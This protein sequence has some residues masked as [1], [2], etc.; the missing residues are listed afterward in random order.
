[1][2]QLAA[3]YAK[4]KKMVGGNRER[5]HY[6]ESFGMPKE[7]FWK[8]TL[9]NPSIRRILAETEFSIRLSEERG[10]EFDA[11]LDEALDFMQARMDE[12]GVL[13]KRTCEEA[14][15]IL[16]P[17]SG[18]AKEYSLILAAHAHIDMNWMWSWNETVA[19]TI[20]T[21]QTMLKLMREYPD[22]HFSQSQ[23]AVYK[24]IEEYAPELKPEMMKYIKEGRWEVTASAWVETDKNMPSTESLLQ[25]IYQTK[26][27]LKEN[28]EIDP[29]SLNIDFSP[30]TFGHSANLPELDALGG[31][32]YYYHCRGLDGDNALYR[33]RAPSGREMIVYRE[34]YWYNS[35]INPLPGIGLIDVARRS[36][37]LKTGLVVYGV[38]DHGGGPTR[39]D[40]ERAMEMMQWPVFPQLRFGTFGEFFK[41][42]ETVRE[43]LPL[44]DHELN[45]IMPGCY[46]TQSRLKMA[47]RKTEAALYDA[48]VWDTFAKCGGVSQ[49]DEKQFASAWQSVLF[50][51]FH[52]IL[53]G[54]CVQDSR[55]HAMGEFAHAAAVAES[56]SALALQGIAGLIDTSD[57]EI[58]DY[59]ENQAEGAGAGYG[60]ENFTGIPSP[61]RGYGF[62]RIYHLYNAGAV[63]RE[64]PCEITVW[65]WTGDMREIAFTGAA[66]ETLPFQLLDEE[67]QQYWDHKYFRV[68]VY[69]KIP[70]FGFTTVVMSQKE[71]EEYR[72]YLQPQG[73]THKPSQNVVLENEHLRA[74]F[75]FMTGELISLTDKKTGREKLACG[76]TGG[77]RYI[78]T[79]KKSSSAWNIGRYERISGPLD[80]TRLHAFEGELCS[81]FEMVQKVRSS[82][83]K[84]T[85][86]L[87]K[88][89]KAFS[90]QMKADWHE[91]T[92]ETVPVLVYRLPIEKTERFLYDVPAGALYREPNHIDLPGL[93]YAAAQDGERLLGLVSDSKYGYRGTEDCLTCTLINATYSPDPYPERGIHEIRLSVGVFAND[94]KEMEEE[95]FRLN[96]AVPYQSGSVHKGSLGKQDSFLQAELGT[97]VLS[98][99]SVQAG[100]ATVRLFE[101]NGAD[102]KITLR[103]GALNVKAAVCCDLL[104]QETG[105]AAERLEDGITLPLR[106]HECLMLKFPL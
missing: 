81:G 84:T 9:P 104:G 68:L 29:A 90:V 22:F 44:V 3:K 24:I 102:T 97:A 40:I 1:M 20:A 79:E 55:E 91:I 101:T 50:T 69:A 33:W 64:Q 25:H 62:T 7:E 2:S 59:A 87:M 23:G 98:G 43:Q 16:L 54:S 71:P 92:G 13:T 5:I 77:L 80:T 106:A 65:D 52:D 27:Y 42:A 85:V 100:F 48:Q 32:D 70:A 6:E 61:E 39:R 19:A 53:T 41:E 49:S 67:L 15:R 28:W 46:T 75:C 12:D 11:L 74:E 30:D 99:I 105:H 37:G 57:I 18:A 103:S 17:L 38:G 88:N 56:R 31:V 96:H 26:K 66:G 51:H 73:R 93:Q 8:V 4:L 47:N 21:F 82:E 60:V 86:T 63:C 35:G 72:I 45:V 76:K 58:A 34:Q 83:I 36:G 94:P 14:E 89:A 95:A 78:D 10:G